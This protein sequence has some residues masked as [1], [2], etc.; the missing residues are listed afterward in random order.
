MTKKTSRQ[1]V[2]LTFEEALARLSEIVAELE[3]EGVNLDRSL[4]LFTE[5]QRLAQ[6]CQDQL[7]E[8]EEQVTTLSR[9][10]EGFQ[11]RPGLSGGSGQTGLPVPDTGEE[12]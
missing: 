3:L 11:E 7:A 2:D 6:L 8:A 1:P 10:A 5:G 9:S 4:E 12:T